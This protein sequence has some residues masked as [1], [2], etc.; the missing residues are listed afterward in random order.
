MRSLRLGLAQLNPTVGDL[1]GN[2]ER[3]VG[4]VGRA[5]ALGVE[6]LAFPELAIT[7]YPPEDLLL[8]PSFVERA[9]RL[10][11]DLRGHDPGR[12]HGEPRG[13]TVRRG[14]GAA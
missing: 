10:T 1:D 3:I 14:R 2:F 5:R 13:G 11:R 9:M 7:G 4:A 12:G 8:H 6:V